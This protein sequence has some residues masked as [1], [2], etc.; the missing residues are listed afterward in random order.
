MNPKRTLSLLALALAALFAAGAQTSARAQATNVTS[1]AS[2][3]IETTAVSC[4][5]DTVTFDGKMHFLMHVTTDASGGRHAVLEIN[6]Q[7][8]KGVGLTG[9]QYTSSTTLHETLTD[10][11][12]V[13]GKLVYTSTVKY[14]VVGQGK[15][16]D[17]LVRMTT[18]ITVDDDGNAVPS[19]PEFTIKCQ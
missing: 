16:P 12:S 11:E 18:H 9:A 7:G 5:G 15:N 8:V 6:T 3:P 13:D 1:T 2:F 14:L 10:P 4:A 19:T 17:F